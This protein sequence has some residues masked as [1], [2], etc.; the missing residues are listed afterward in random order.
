MYL[1]IIEKNLERQKNLS[2]TKPF[3]TDEGESV[4]TDPDLEYKI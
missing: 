2:L 1:I 3:K 4:L